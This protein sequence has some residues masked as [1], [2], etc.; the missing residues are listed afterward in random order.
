MA[1]ITYRYL[2]GLLLLFLPFAISTPIVAENLKP[3]P[4]PSLELIGKTKQ[5]R[6]RH[7]DTLL[8]V[9]RSEGLGFIELVAANPGIDPW[10]PTVDS[11]I[12]IPSWH[13]LPDGSRDGLLLNLADQRLYYFTP[14]GSVESYAIGTGREGWE[15]PQGKTKIIKKVENPIWYV[16]NS[17]QKEDPTLPKAVLP[18][19]KNP[20]GKHAFYLDW[21]G[22]LIHGTNQPWGVGRRVSH[23]CVRMYPEDI[24]KIYSRISLGTAVT[25]INQEAKLAWSDNQ[26]W[27]EIHPSQSQNLELEEKKTLSPSFVPELIFRVRD[28]SQGQ[29]SKVNWETVR[30]AE[31]ERKGIP[32]PILGR[33]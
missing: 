33:R 10:L 7:K 11:K 23:G 22:Y 19:P 5:Y 28:K 26:L 17:I 30:R 18:G 12:T 15:T 1:K 3:T 6:I 29:F 2:R 27:L 9:A 4:A 21:P 16:P 13:L 8:D 25:I 24:E 20:L 32:I 14:D 31:R